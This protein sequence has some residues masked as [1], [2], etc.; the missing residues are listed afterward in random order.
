CLNVGCI[1]SKALIHEANDFAIVNAAVKNG[2][3]GLTSST[4]TADM[5][6]TTATVRGVVQRL[7]GGVA[8]LVKRA[9]VRSITGRADIVDGKTVTITAAGDDGTESVETVRTKHL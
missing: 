8:S 5:A 3:Y 9:G 4:A 1:P 7:T 6:D 2:R